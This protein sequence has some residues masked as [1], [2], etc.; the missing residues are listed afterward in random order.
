MNKVSKAD[1]TRLKTFYKSNLIRLFLS[2][3]EWTDKKTGEARS[4]Y[5]Y[6]ANNSVTI[7]LPHS[8][9]AN[10]DTG[11]S[12]SEDGKLTLWLREMT[13]D[14]YDLYVD[15][16]LEEIYLNVDTMEHPSVNDVSKEMLKDA[17]IQLSAN[18]F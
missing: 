6:N 18:N 10:V 14:V 7:K 1:A 5:V 3:V 16:G 9:K 11:Q 17:R 2:L 13:E 12:F 4:C 15:D 8:M